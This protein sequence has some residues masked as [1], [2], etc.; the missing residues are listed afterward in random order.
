M[1]TTARGGSPALRQDRADLTGSCPEV[2]SQRLR[3]A[4]IFKQEENT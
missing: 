3:V 4:S 2:R 1:E